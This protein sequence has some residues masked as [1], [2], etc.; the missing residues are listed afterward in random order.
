MSHV[1]TADGGTE[2]LRV[3][4]TISKADVWHHMPSPINKIHGWSKRGAEC[5]RLAVQ[6]RYSD[7]NLPGEANIS[8][9]AIDAMAY[10]TTCCTVV[11]LDKNGA[12]RPALMWMMCASI[13]KPRPYWRQAIS[14][15][16]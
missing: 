13:R 8:G 14:A 10:A 2:S 6:P 5:R 9:D 15:S 3:V 7:A 16:F 12:L 1:L 11:A 4:S